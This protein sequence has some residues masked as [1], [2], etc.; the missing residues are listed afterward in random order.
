[1]MRQFTF[2]RASLANVLL[3]VGL[4]L[5]GFSAPIS[6]TLFSLGIVLVI[7]G[8]I[9]RGNWWESWRAAT[10]Y[11]VTAPLLIFLGY[12]LVTTT[13]SDGDWEHT[14]R[15]L[16]AYLMLLYLPLVLS[17][18]GYVTS[19]QR[20]IDVFYA[21]CVCLLVMVWTD[22]LVDLP[23]SRE[24]GTG[25]GVNHTI[26]MTY[27]S[28]GMALNGCAL[29]AWFKAKMAE[30]VWKRS[31]HYFV[32]ALALIGVF[33][34]NGSRIG[35]ITGIGVTLVLVLSSWRERRGG[36]ALATV[37]VGLL[38]AAVFSP[39]LENRIDQLLTDLL[40]YTSPESADTSLGTRLGM[41]ALSLELISQ[42]PIFGHGLGDYRLMALP[43]FD[44]GYARS[45]SAIAPTNQ[46][47]FIGVEMGLVGVS[48]F[49]FVI[50]CLLRPLISVAPPYKSLAAGAAWIVFV[51]A[52][53]HHPIWDAGERQISLLL[54]LLVC[55][56][57]RIF[58]QQRQEES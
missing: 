32:C 24:R 4:Y 15:V 11:P 29:Y 5:M 6:L 50:A 8:W 36:G 19:G 30:S 58:P 23:W 42:A 51:D 56:V 48:L 55:V 35:Y 43:F 54:V 53:G 39:L 52:M 37:L 46:I 14:G 34:L 10:A 17:C 20:L 44:E 1:M 28:Q 9:L 26:F 38:V 21:G 3:T 16:G 45:A 12:V 49:A 13:Y 27:I 33:A 31:F 2:D 22:V 41:A 25:F 7:T 57:P 18:Y 40:R 47:L